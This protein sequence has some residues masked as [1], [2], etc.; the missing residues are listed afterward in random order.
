MARRARAQIRIDALRYFRMLMSMFVV[1]MEAAHITV[2]M[3][4]GG[5]IRVAVVMRDDSDSVASQESCSAS[6]LRSTIEIRNLYLL[7]FI[8]TQ[9][10]LG[11]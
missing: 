11:S 7:G 4:S 3:R 8:F 1:S 2:T 5:V 9:T 10:Y 6:W